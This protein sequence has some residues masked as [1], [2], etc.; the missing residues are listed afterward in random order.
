M[1][2]F[3]ERVYA[4]ILASVDA[5]FGAAPPEPLDEHARENAAI[6]AFLEERLE[7]Y[8]V[9]SQQPVLDR[10]RAHAEGSGGNGYLMGR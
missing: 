10:L 5:E 6:E 1:E 2:A 3:G 4:D 7:R 9:G 8:V